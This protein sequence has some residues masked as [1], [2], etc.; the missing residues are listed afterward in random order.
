MYLQS[1]ITMPPGSVL[2]TKQDICIIMGKLAL[3]QSAQGTSLFDCP[4]TECSLMVFS[5]SA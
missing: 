1:V 2:V 3:V 5:L 4:G